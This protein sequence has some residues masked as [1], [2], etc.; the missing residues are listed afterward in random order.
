MV[1]PVQ[2]FLLAQWAPFQ[3]LAG[4][5][6]EGDPCLRVD[7]LWGSS[8]SL[9]AS[10][11]LSETRRPALVLVSDRSAL[12]RMCRDLRFF[13]VALRASSRR[14]AE[15]PPGQPTFWRGRPQREEAGERAWVCYRLLRGEPLTVVTLPAALSSLLPAPEEFRRRVFSLAVGDSLAREEL[16][17]RLEIAGYERV[18]MVVEVGQ[19]SL[20]G[21]I[22]DVFSPVRQGPA[23]VEFFGDEIESIRLFDP[24]SQRSLERLESVEVLPLSEQKGAEATLLT[25]LGAEAP[26]ILDDPALLENPRD[27]APSAIP[28]GDRKST[29]LNSSHIQKSRMPSSA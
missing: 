8:R 12:D 3:A 18:E 5:F 29:R 11:L 2:P 24:T 26:V 16:L 25:Y 20:R 10:A 28:L 9:V 19:W 27:G 13:E 4:A 14:V 7:G 6:A 21:G 22:V 23:R 1:V 17:E 15:F